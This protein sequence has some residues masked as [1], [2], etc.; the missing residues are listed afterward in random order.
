MDVD[1]GTQEA[2]TGLLT[3]AR[4]LTR[5]RAGSVYVR[6][7]HYLHFVAVQNDDLAAAMGEA[8]TARLVT[9][10]PLRWSERSIAS[11]VALT[12]A[13][14]NIAD[15]YRIPPDKP[16]SFNPRLD[17]ETGFHTTS[18]LVVP[19]RSAMGAVYGVLQLINATD[20]RG[21]IVPFARDAERVIATLAAAAAA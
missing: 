15:V 10:R 4:R 20:E 18:M 13:A 6:D 7:E 21:T 17:C 9:R 19:L 16:Y 5:A 3:D 1:P 11:Y 2:L 8:E 14:L 12:S